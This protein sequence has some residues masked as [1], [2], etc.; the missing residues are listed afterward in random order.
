[1]FFRDVIG[2]QDVIE[3]LVKDAQAGTVPHALLFCGPEGVGKLQTAIAFARYLL[4]ALKSCFCLLQGTQ[5]AGRGGP[6]C[7][8]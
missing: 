5:S 3:R 8:S 6:A 4:T 7:P 2:Q 1:M